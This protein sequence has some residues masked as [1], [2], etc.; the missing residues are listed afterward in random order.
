[1]R[2]F[3]K[4]SPKRVCNILTGLLI[5]IDDEYVKRDDIY[6]IVHMSSNCAKNHPEWIN[7]FLELEQKLIDNNI[8]GKVE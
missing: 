6:K 8:I 2:N 7:D 1:M 3:L 4:I 5:A